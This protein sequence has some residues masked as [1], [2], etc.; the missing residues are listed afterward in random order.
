MEGGGRRKWAA[1]STAVERRRL[2][3]QRGAWA[4]LPWCCAARVSRPTG[5]AT[6]GAKTA[7]YTTTASFVLS[8]VI[9]QHAEPN[10]LP[11]RKSTFCNSTRTGVSQLAPVSARYSALWTAT[12]LPHHRLHAM[13]HDPV[14]SISPS[15][16]ARPESEPRSSC[17][18]RLPTYGNAPLPLPSS[19]HM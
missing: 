17:K 8:T 10:T 14:A 2:A 5:W 18:A 6:H 4:R 16:P 3:A 1:R 9:Q 11:T 15:C 13:L 19:V 12:R 7:V